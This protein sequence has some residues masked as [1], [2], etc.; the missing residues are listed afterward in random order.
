MSDGKGR[1]SI[2]LGHFLRLRALVMA[3]VRVMDQMKR[4]VSRPVQV[5]GLGSVSSIQTGNSWLLAPAGCA[6][7]PARVA[8]LG[9]PSGFC[10]AA[11][12]GTSSQM[13]QG[14]DQRACSGVSARGERQPARVANARGAL[15]PS[16]HTNPAQCWRWGVGGA[17]H[18]AG[19]SSGG[20][21]VAQWFAHPPG[22]GHAGMDARARRTGNEI[23]QTHADTR[24]GRRLWRER[25]T[26]YGRIRGLARQSTRTIRPANVDAPKPTDR[27]A[28]E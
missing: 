15:T 18:P 8:V 16:V 7:A 6:G 13:L 3:L 10:C 2:G 5:L 17:S 11:A 22:A 9:C 25:A 19:W 26:T 23:N 14:D 4:H 21:A 27:G 20:A 28:V 12:C 24:S 1:W